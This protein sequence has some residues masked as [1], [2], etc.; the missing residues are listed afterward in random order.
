[1]DGW[2]SSVGASN[3]QAN[4]ITEILSWPKRQAAILTLIFVYTLITAF[5][6]QRI[7]VVN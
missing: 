2:A 1:M 6:G 5:Q 7:T 3:K 4:L